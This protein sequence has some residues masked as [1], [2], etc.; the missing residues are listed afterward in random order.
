MEDAAAALG[1]SPSS[2][3]SSSSS[4]SPSPSSAASDASEL[5]SADPFVSRFSH[6]R[7]LPASVIA[8]LTSA[9]PPL[10]PHPPLPHLKETV[11][12][13]HLSLPP[14]PSPPPPLPLPTSPPT[15]SSLHIHP[16][17]HPQW[18]SLTSRYQPPSSPTPSTPPT[19]PPPSS[20]PLTHPL[21]RWLLPLLTSY[22]DL[23]WGGVGWGVRAA[24]TEAL[25]LHC[26][27]HVWKSRERVR[28]HDARLREWE[29][30]ER[31]REE[32]E[33]EE[34]RRAKAEAKAKG[35]R[36]VH[37]RPPPAPLPPPPPAPPS[38][39]DQGYT[40]CTV[41]YLLPLAN[42][43]Y[44][45]ITTLLS[46]LPPSCTS[47]LLHHRR[48]L[49]D[50]APTP[51]VQPDPSKPADF[52]ALFSGQLNDAFRIGLA[53]GAKATTL[54]A[55]FTS[56]DI[57]VASPLGLRMIVQEEG[58]DWLSSVELLVIDCAEVL[59]MQNWAHLQLLLPYINRM[60]GGE[61]PEG[62]A[63]GEEGAVMREVDFS[64]VREYLLQ[65]HA[66]FYRQT[67]VLGSY[68]TQDMM[69]LVT[70]EAGGGEAGLRNYAGLVLLRP[71][72]SG[73]LS[74]L[75]LS[76][77]RHRQVFHRFP[78]TFLTQYD[79]RF[80]HFTSTVLPA[81]RGAHEA[82]GHVLLFIPE[83]ADFLRLRHHFQR[84]HLSYAAISEYSKAADLTRNRANFYH[85]RVKYLLITERLHYFRRY[86][87]RGVR[88]VLFY[89]LPHNAH[90]YAEVANWMGS[91]PG[92]NGGEVER[93]VAGRSL[94]MCI[95]LYTQ[96]DARE[97][98][99]VVGTQ[100]ALKMMEVERSAYVFC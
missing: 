53:V 92:Q 17:L 55:P 46:L 86:R 100:R 67:I 12:S 56:A 75:L 24:T 44:H 4:S 95:S 35:Q 70:G 64:R 39:R 77:D 37:G 27:N 38:Y 96:W 61:R 80:A 87:I 78:S 81:V 23:V 84:R 9:P 48:F 34:K 49:N 2:P 52:R 30:R 79:D 93:A 5:L 25:C 15:L 20:S 72:Y 97:L 7:V 88:H 60:P 41:L 51:E 85:G 99:R 8:A 28:G 74:R 43:A 33:R 31:E 1:R 16:K 45:A 47:T 73:E 54:Y 82:E 63:K 36:K 58:G 14:A 21:H 69:S 90:F 3:S 65:G 40:R 26:V 66:R 98:E 13:L 83:Y 42:L 50:F 89:S 18:T 22:T 32:G 6:H 10:T 59:S 71:Q 29:R 76:G 19:C 62:G 91:E 94:C 11:L 57:V 68:L